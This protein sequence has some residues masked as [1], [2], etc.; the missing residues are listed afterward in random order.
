[1]YLTK[2]SLLMFVKLNLFETLIVLILIIIILYYFDQFLNARHF[3]CV[4]CVLRL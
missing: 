4:F 2:W 1:M 3:V